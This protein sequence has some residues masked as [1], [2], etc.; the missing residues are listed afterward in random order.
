MKPVTLTRDQSMR[1]MV[2]CNCARSDR[3][4][5][6]LS[7]RACIEWQEGRLYIMCEHCGRL[8]FNQEEE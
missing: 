7:P 8:E 6:S 1:C 5:W 3:N 2:Q 4:G